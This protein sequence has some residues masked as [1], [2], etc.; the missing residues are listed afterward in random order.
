[1]KRATV[2]FTVNEVI[3]EQV[4]SCLSQLVPHQ[5]W[6]AIHETVE[7]TFCQNSLEMLKYYVSK[8]KEVDTVT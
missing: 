1:M 3:L 2:F 8:L 5:N 6:C 4:V 7:C